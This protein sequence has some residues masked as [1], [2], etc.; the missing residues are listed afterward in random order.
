[1]KLNL[2]FLSF[3]FTSCF[4][5]K[6]ENHLSGK[7]AVNVKDSF[8]VYSNSDLT[9][10]R[11]KIRNDSKVS[12]GGFKW[13][14]N[15]DLLVGTEYIDSFGLGTVRGNIALFDIAG[16]IV[17]LIYKSQENEIAQSSF[18]SK[19]DS[20]LL[21]TI[22]KRGDVMKNPF[23]GLTR[24]LSIVILNFKNKQVIKNIK[25][26]GSL[27]NFEL[28]ESPWLYDENHF[29]YSILNERVIMSNNT[30]INPVN[31]NHT[32]IYMYDLKTDQKKLILSDAH[33][34]ICSPVNEQIGYIKE[35][36]V[37]IMNLKK[38]T[39]K[40]IYKAEQDEKI[41]NI[42]WTPNGRHIYVASAINHSADSVE[43]REKL[44]DIDTGKE[45]QFKKI[46]HG[47]NYYTWK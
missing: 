37:G 7:I 10:K 13:I 24:T 4:M 20:R 17:E 38:G 5:T 36:S 40:I 12:Y 22:E 16:N 30:R 31:N 34:G 29:V 44:I 26:I 28:S 15:E 42:H 21:F 47:F 43:P 9:S 19:N 11:F 45:L 39:I 1:M 27:P 3:F 6:K 14:N 8:L 18:I 2:L 41:A 23:E 33:F 35:Q 46:G 25:D 32:G